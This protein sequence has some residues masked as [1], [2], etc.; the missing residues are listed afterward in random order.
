[1]KVYLIDD[2]KDRQSNDY[3]WT[4]LRFDRF[5][6][7]INCIYSLDEL[8]KRS[9]EVFSNDNIILYHES[10]VDKT[11]KSKIADEK[12]KK[13]L[14]WSDKTDNLL[15]YFSGSKNY[16]K[17]K[18]NIAHI[19]VSTLYSNLEIF[20]DKIQSNDAKLE[21]LLFGENVKLEEDLISIGKQAFDLTFKEAPQSSEGQ[22]LFIRSASH[23]ISKPLIDVHTKDL[24][25]EPSDEKLAKKIN[26]WLSEL[27]YDNIFL[28]LCFGSTFSDF[29]GL[30]LATLIRCIPTKNQTSR[31][32][33]YSFIGMEFLL[34][35]PFFNILKTKN[36]ELIPFS[37]TAFA[38]FADKKENM[39][40]QDELATELY[41]LKLDIPGDYFDS[42]HIAN[43]WGIYQMAR[44]ANIKIEE[45]DGFEKEKLDSVYFKWLIA[46][47]GL[48]DELPES[49]IKHQKVYA[50][51][52]PGIT[53]VGKIDL[54]NIPRR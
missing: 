46:K 27:K 39:F 23:P 53:Q 16:R 24:I 29:N 14:E 2:K 35:N 5:R 51:K 34:D 11:T 48:Y 38:E 15:V 17:L 36:I 50:N 12:R 42:H 25:G 13:L 1:M 18:N 22:N 33:I 54:T 9:K 6:D 3:K 47:N 40:S 19:P 41:K 4:K 31:I 21:Y 37:K 45:I 28:P 44:N 32:Y 7:V 26:E 20:L 43:E 52:L 8:E 10:F 49:Q 30:R